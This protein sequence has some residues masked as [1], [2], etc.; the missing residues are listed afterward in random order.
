VQA[1]KTKMNTKET[2]A[3]LIFDEFRKTKSRANHIVMMQVFRFSLIPKLNP[4]E[5]D[6][7]D[8]VVNALIDNGY[9]IYEK[10]SPEC[11]RLT[12]KGFDY[13]YDD[14]TGPESEGIIKKK[15]SPSVELPEELYR[16]VIETIN[17]Y[18]K[19]LEQK[20]KLYKGH[21][22]EGLRD[23]FLANLT[24]RYEKVTTTGETFNSNGKTD[25]LLKDD[26]GNNLFIA[27]CKW[28]NGPSVFH[29]TI[30]QLFENYVTWRD[31]KLA[32]LFFVKN[33]DFSN[34][35]K[36]IESEASKH[37]YFVEF[38]EVKDKTSFRFL[39]KQ[40][41]DENNKVSL[42]IMFFHFTEK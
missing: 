20:P 30:D 9:L 41:D 5:Q 40:K 15:N 8:D 31:T 13:I 6:I 26:R 2:I 23:H 4:K 16:N 35:L 24:G 32:I 21:D 28:W 18:G 10:S 1:K 34:V 19:D 25:I 11:L 14:T 37:K 27:E 12:E 22:E 29:S 17:N 7:F 3:E 36:Q 39:F 38:I 42:E 33:K